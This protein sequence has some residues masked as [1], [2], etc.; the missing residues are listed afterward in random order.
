MPINEWLNLVE[1][2]KRCVL[3]VPEEFLCRELPPAPILAAAINQ[4]FDGFLRDQRLLALQ[5]SK[6]FR[7][8]PPNDQLK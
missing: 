2:T 4:V 8:P 7:I 5:T 6:A 3:S 1:E